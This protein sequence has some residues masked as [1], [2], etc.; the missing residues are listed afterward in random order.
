MEKRR[1]LIVDDSPVNVDIL[2]E[3]L[4][5]EFELATAETGEDALRQ[6]PSFAPDI[7]LL[8]IMM[9][10]IDGYETCRRIKAGPLGPFTQVILVSGKGSTEERLEGYQAGADDYIVKPFDH[11]E[12]LAK[13][14]V[15][16][17]L[18]EAV[19]K[20][21]KAN[22]Q[23][24]TFNEHLEQLVQARTAEIIATRDL[25]IFSLAQL[26]DSRDPETGDHLERIRHYSRI[27]ADELMRR[28]PYT[29]RIDE[30]F[31]ENLYRSSPL[32]DIGK[33]GI[34]DSILLKPGRLTKE[35]F[36][37]M[38]THTV[39]GHKALTETMSRNQMGAFLQ[40]A[41]DIARHHHEKW[42]GRGYPDGLADED[43]PLPARI[44]A[45]ADVFDA[46]TSYRI[47]KPAW[48]LDKAKNLI[49]TEAG[50]H[51]DP[52]VAQA[53]LNRWNEILEIHEV[54]ANSP[55]PQDSQESP[56]EELLVT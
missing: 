38:K 7:V 42:D 5:D 36:E 2:V 20:L 11:D 22:A 26:A 54:L 49:E 17:R 41:A 51:F 55:E 46:L 40:M 30:R 18:R 56:E 34:P 33:V 1:I 25:L 24:R 21:W 53:F 8:D 48:D 23:I 52:A 27:I 47:Y 45:V 3:L 12:L 13:L 10:G 37:V 32:H 31:I 28:G 29:D 4:E 14:A 6:L 9:P 39:I 16:L 15:Q 35:E 19:E 50:K 43:I 44:V